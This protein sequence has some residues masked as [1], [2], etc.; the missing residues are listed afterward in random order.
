[1]PRLRPTRLLAIAG[2]VLVAL[3]L[4]EA[5][6]HLPAHEAGVAGAARRGRDAARPEGTARATARAGRRP[7]AARARGAAARPREA[8][9]SGSSSSRASLPGASAQQALTDRLACGAWTTGSRRAAARACAACVPA[10]RRALP[11]RPAGGHRAGAVRRE[12]PPVPDPVLRHVPLPRRRDL[13]PRGGGRCRA[14]DARRRRPS[15]S[16]RASLARRAGR[17]ACAAARARAGIGGSTRSGSLKCLH[18]HAA[19]ALARPGYELG[20]RILAE[21]PS[22]VARLLLYSLTWTSSSR[23]SSGRTATAES[24]R[25]AS[26]RRHYVRLTGQVDLIVAGAPPAHR[27]DLHARRARR[28]VRRRRAAGRAS[29]STTP[30]PRRR[31]RPSRARSRTPRSTSMRVARRTTT[32]EARPPP[33][34]RPRARLPRR[35]GVRRGA[36]RQPGTGRHPNT[37]SDAEAVAACA[38][39]PRDRD[40]DSTKSLIRV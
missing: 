34:R 10:R 22:A 27:A 8:R 3:P 39:G 2:L 35:A 4:L 38:C 23:V 5:G 30:T 16:S 15:R 12:R 37:R 36:A 29:C 1:M 32:R 17:A 18:A 21:L 40:G 14:L 26:T 24:R 25:R 20:E 31:R 6:A 9:A 11:V 7:A 19:F 33:R 13:A 28:R